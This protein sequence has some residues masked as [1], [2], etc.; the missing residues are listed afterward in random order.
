MPFVNVMWR[1]VTSIEPGLNSNLNMSQ[2]LGPQFINY[3]VYK[4]Y[5][6]H[7]KITVE[8]LFISSKAKL[9][10]PTT[11]AYSSIVWRRISIR[12]FNGLV[13]REVDHHIAQIL[14]PDVFGKEKVLKQETDP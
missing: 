14:L 11:M 6:L 5:F 2:F 12:S 1:Y 9:N 10:C 3:Y 13:H 7:R 4:A 8:S